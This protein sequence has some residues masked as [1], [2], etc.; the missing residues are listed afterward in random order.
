MNLSAKK[1]NFSKITQ[2]SKVR[3]VQSSLPKCVRLKAVENLN[4]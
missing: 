4:A 2:A 3:A 1:I